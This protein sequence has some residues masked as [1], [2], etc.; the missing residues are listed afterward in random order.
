[1]KYT[2]KYGR[3]ILFHINILVFII[4]HIYFINYK[5]FK[6]TWDDDERNNLME[7]L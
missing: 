2:H 1:M 3:L 7:N 4:M 6:F 5:F